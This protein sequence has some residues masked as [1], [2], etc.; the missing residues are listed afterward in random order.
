MWCPCSMSDSALFTL[1]SKI[2]ITGLFRYRSPRIAD[3]ASYWFTVIFSSPVKPIYTALPLVWKFIWPSVMILSSAYLPSGGGGIVFNV[4]V[5]PRGTSYNSRKRKRYLNSLITWQRVF[6]IL[7]FPNRG[8]QIRNF[9]HRS[10]RETM[11]FRK[12]KDAR[13]RPTHQDYRI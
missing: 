9:C 2:P 12:Q 1:I 10:F 11:G 6:V 4:D 13:Y 7:F 3:W 5:L 8:A